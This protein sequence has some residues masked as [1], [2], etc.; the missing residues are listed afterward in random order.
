MRP[1]VFEC[2][3]RI[4]FGLHTPTAVYYTERLWFTT[5]TLNQGPQ[6]MWFRVLLIC[7]TLV[8]AGLL[9]WCASHESSDPQILG[10]YSRSY[11]MVLTGFAVVTV[12]L[13]LA[14]WG[15][16]YRRLDVL[17]VKLLA[18]WCRYSWC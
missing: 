1:F 14:H 16:I 3:V 15:P 7:L 18:S 2:C 13:C 6:F 11:A 9:A 12:A 17:R 10:R 4:D 8:V 5:R